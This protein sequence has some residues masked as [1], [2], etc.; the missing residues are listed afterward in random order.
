MITESGKII[1]KTSP[2][3]HVTRDDYLQVEIKVEIDWFNRCINESLDDANFVVDGKGEFDSMYLED[4]KEENYLGIRHTNDL[5]TLTATEYDDMHT[6]DRPDD[7][8]EEAID[9]YLNV[10]LIMDVGTN[11]KQCGCIVKHLWGLDSEPIGRLHNNATKSSSQTDLVRSTKQISSQRTCLHKLTVKATS[12]YYSKRLPITN[13]TTVL[14]LY[15]MGWCRIQV[16][17]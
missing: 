2:G 12:I 3:E 11:D 6:D 14:Y 1:S 17:L 9:K 15:L 13:M 16:E 10:E 5:N 7:D 4:I 8:D